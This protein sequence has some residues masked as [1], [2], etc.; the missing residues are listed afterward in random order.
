MHFLYNTRIITYAGRACAALAEERDRN[1]SQWPPPYSERGYRNPL[2]RGPC[3][4]R[5]VCVYLCVGVSA[6]YI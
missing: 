5:C 1:P 6:I 2:P 3:Q 4:G